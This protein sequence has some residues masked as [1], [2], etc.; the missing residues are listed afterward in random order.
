MNT[1]TP[2]WIWIQQAVGQGSCA[3]PQ[4]LKAFSSPEEVYAADRIAL[5][6][7]GITGKPL[8]NLCGKSLDAAKRLAE[9]C[10][11]MG[12]ILTPEDEAYPDAL[13]HIYSPP[14]VLYGKGS[15]PELGRVPVLGIVGTRR[16]TP[17][18]EKV[19]GGLAAG[20]AAAGCVVVSGGARGI[21]HAAHEGA[22]YAGGYTLVVQACGLNVDYPLINS[23]MRRHVLEEGGTIL[24]EY[25]PDVPAFRNH[26]EVRNRLIS[27]M[28]W[29]VC[30]VEAPKSSGS[31][32]TARCAREQGRDVFVVPG[33][34]TAKNNDGS[35]ELIKEG[36]QL[37]THPSEILREYQYR[38]GG[39][40]N[41]Q[42]ADRARDAYY[43]FSERVTHPL[44]SAAVQPH[45]EDIVP[46]SPCPN[47][48]S[49]TAKQVY[50]A[51]TDTPVTA[52]ELYV[53]TGIA[54]GKL[55]SALTELEL[56]GC[57]RSH[58]GN[59]YSR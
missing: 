53:T 26:F 41:E 51:L 39:L 55:F 37:I 20:L 36:A 17:Y 34:I 46:S 1:S 40:L 5:Q 23:D 42:E 45:R 16:A 25:Q 50:A 14:L 29:G 27:G 21:D 18:G 13:R 31:L 10:E 56:Y 32:I 11:N 28:A 43:A 22:L 52:E 7:A 9:R 12:W 35:H 38:T 6:Q 47:T 59:R 4:L 49:D 57:V 30:V 58:A 24:T 19:A 3:V 33:N 15:L 44:P 2:Y 8:E 48:A 54:V